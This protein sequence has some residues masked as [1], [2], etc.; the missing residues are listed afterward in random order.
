M[1]RW[2]WLPL[3]LAAAVFLADRL[4]PPPLERIDAPGSALVLARDGSPLR[5]FADAGGVWRYRVRID[6][7]AP[8]Y[9]DALL[10]YEDRW[11]FH[12]PGI[13]PASMLRALAQAGLHG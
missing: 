11:F 1:R 12:H 8:V 7:V 10:N 9:I 6:Q 2:W 4:D 5:A 13:N 3:I